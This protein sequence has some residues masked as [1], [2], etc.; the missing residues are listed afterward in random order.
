MQENTAESVRLNASQTIYHIVARSTI[1]SVPLCGSEESDHCV[2]PEEATAMC[3]ESLCSDC[4][5]IFNEG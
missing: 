4:V 1:D 5:R 3:R 2:T